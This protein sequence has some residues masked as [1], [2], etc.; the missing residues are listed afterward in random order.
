MNLF[1]CLFVVDAGFF[2]NLFLDCYITIEHVL[3][4]IFVLVINAHDAFS[5][6]FTIS[7]VTCQ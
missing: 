6:D 3:C 1:F 2:F 7:T 5:L 4:F